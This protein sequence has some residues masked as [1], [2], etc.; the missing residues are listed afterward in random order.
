[1]FVNEHYVCDSRVKH[2]TPYDLYMHCVNTSKKCYY[3]K[4]VAEYLYALYNTWWEF[5]AVPNPRTNKI[6]PNEL[7]HCGLD[8]IGS[9]RFQ[10]FAQNWNRYAHNSMLMYNLDYF[11]FSMLNLIVLLPLVEAHLNAASKS[12]SS[13]IAIMSSN[14]SL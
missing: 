4:L 6:D 1:M 9:K 3:H 14:S 5:D 12:S 8:Y 10:R 2:Y 13:E 7:R 11:L